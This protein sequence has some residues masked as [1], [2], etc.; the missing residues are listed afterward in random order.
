[1]NDMRRNAV[2]ILAVL[3]V[4][5][6][7][8]H[9]GSKLGDVTSPTD[10]KEVVRFHQAVQFYGD[11]RLEDG[12]DAL[13]ATGAEL[14]I[15]DGV[16]ATASELN[17]AAD[18]SARLTTASVTNGQEI[19]LSAS[20]P[21]ITL[22]GTG[23]PDDNTNTITI[24]TPYPVGQEFTFIV[25]AASSNLISIADSTTVVALGA[26]WVGDNTDT[27]KILTTATNAAVKISAS[28]N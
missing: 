25:A 2:A 28:D 13:T 5:A 17:A 7:G 4:L 21:I 23:S 10:F 12:G 11:V 18:L 19:T 8:A 1:M 3:V 24:A 22:T 27:L 15:M 14:N 16:T 20:T 26:N 6:G 9:A